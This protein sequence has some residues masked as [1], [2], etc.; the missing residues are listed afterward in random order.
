MVFLL[1]LDLDRRRVT[2][3]GSMDLERGRSRVLDW[4]EWDEEVDCMP[5]A[6]AVIFRVVFFLMMCPE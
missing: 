2:V 5:R 1:N 6:V 4:D 3:D